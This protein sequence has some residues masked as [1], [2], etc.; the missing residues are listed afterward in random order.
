VINGEIVRSVD[1]VDAPAVSTTSTG[2]L[3]VSLG[4]RMYYSSA[5]SFAASS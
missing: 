1:S 2:V 4:I 5:S 3:A